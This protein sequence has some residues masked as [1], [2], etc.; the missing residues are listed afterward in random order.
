[1]ATHLERIGAGPMTQ[2]CSFLDPRDW[3]R[4]G[5]ASKACQANYVKLPFTLWI[6]RFDEETKRSVEY[7]RQLELT[8]PLPDFVTRKICEHCKGLHPP[9]DDQ[10]IGKICVSCRHLLVDFPEWRTALVEMQTRGWDDK[11]REDIGV[12][13]RNS[14]VKK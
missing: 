9:L 13:I 1:M 8:T 14:P 4:I 2:I 11:W 6:L 5:W 3:A 10:T 7:Y 12:C